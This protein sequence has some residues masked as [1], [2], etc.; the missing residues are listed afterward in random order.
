MPL[1]GILLK[2]KNVLASLASSTR[3]FQKR[4]L[5]YLKLFWPIEVLKRGLYRSVEKLRSSLLWVSDS[6]RNSSFIW[7][8]A[9]LWRI[10][11]TTFTVSNSISCSIV[12]QSSSCT[13]GSEGASKQLFVATLPALFCSFC[14]FCRVVVP[15]QC[16][17]CYF[18]IKFPDIFHQML[19][20]FP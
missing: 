5:L 17:H 10:L 16:C 19:L 15:T 11:Y 3:L 13:S 8:G 6:L 9:S 1:Q 7:G 4:T 2:E 18:E 20:I 12:R 14:N